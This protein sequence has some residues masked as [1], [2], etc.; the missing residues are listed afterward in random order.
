[1]FVVSGLDFLTREVFNT[2]KLG[3]DITSI[4]KIFKD[5]GYTLDDIDNLKPAGKAV[6][7][8]ELLR[9]KKLT[10][11]EYHDIMKN[12]FA[13]DTKLG[14]SGVALSSFLHFGAIY[15]DFYRNDTKVVELNR[16][17]IMHGANDAFANKVNCVK[18]FTYL[19]LMLEMEPVLRIVFNET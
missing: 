7:L 11:D 2:N 9:Q 5:A 12:G 4:N 3:R 15:Y 16:H 14:L 10:T 1:M 13:E 8:N 6:K 18:L 17:A 19:Y